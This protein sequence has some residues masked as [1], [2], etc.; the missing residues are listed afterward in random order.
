MILCLLCIE[1]VTVFFIENV[2]VFFYKV[3]Q[4]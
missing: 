4:T 3:N 1:N 2:T